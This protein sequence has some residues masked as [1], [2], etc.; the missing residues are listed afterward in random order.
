MTKNKK[1]QELFHEFNK[2][3]FGGRLPHYRVKVEGYIPNYDGLCTGKIYRKQ[4]LILLVPQDEP[5]M[6]KTLIHEMAHAA[7]NV[8][9]AKTWQEEMKRLLRMGAPVDKIELEPPPERKRM[10]K[11]A[12]RGEAEEVVRAVPDV[13]P[14]RFAK[15]LRQENYCYGKSTSD[16]LRKY[17]WVSRV[18]SEAKAENRKWQK[19]RQALRRK[20]LNEDGRAPNKSSFS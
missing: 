17:P 18:L 12:V 6:E 7:T 13:T 2:K 20:F 8:Y 5:T 14:W 16:F 11:K 15:W 3:Y 10:T 9:H 1:Y 19:V 4:R